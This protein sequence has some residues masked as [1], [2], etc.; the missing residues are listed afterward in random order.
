[1][2]LRAPL[3]RT[4]SS[5]VC[6]SRR[7]SLEERKASKGSRSIREGVWGE[8]SFLPVLHKVAIAAGAAIRKNERKKEKA[9]AAEAPHNGL[10]EA[11]S[12]KKEGVCSLN[13]VAAP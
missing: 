12:S 4:S 13:A 6:R 3:S 9:R 11:C 5:L 10:V 2:V 7:L 8:H 1:R